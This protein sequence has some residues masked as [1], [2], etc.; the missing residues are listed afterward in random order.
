MITPSKPHPPLH[1]SPASP[2]ARVVF[3]CGRMDAHLRAL[4][5]NTARRAWLDKEFANWT[6]LYERYN[7]MVASRHYIIDPEMPNELDY[8]CTLS[9]IDIRRQRLAG[10]G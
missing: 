10:E 9:E 5:S 2:L 7:A 3:Y 8:S 1:D 4:T 6:A